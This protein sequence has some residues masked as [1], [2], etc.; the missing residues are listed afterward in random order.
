MQR[1]NGKVTSPPS[2]LQDTC[3]FANFFILVFVDLTARLEAV[4]KA[5]SEERAA[6]LAIDQSLAE[7][8]ATQQIIDQSLQVSHEPS[9]A[10]NQICNRPRLPS[11]LPR[12]S[13]LQN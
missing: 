11:L 4:E 7:E 1:L 13:C 3:S 5:L 10:L 8:K 6:Q 9:A 12:R 2:L